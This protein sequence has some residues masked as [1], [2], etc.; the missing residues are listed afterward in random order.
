[1]KRSVQRALQAIANVKVTP[2]FIP[3]VG[4]LDLVTPPLSRKPGVL[5]SSQNFEAVKDGGYRRIAGYERFN[6]DDAPSDAAYSIMTAT[7]TGAVVVGDT[8]TGL[9]SGATGVVIALPGGSFVLTKIVGTFQN[10]ESLQ[11][12][13]VT[14][15]TSTSIATANTASTPLLHAT[16]MNA[17]ADAY[18]SDIAAV[19]GEGAIL[20]GFFYSGVNY[21]FRNAVGGA[22]AALYK[23]T[24]SG[25]SLVALGRE[26]AFTS[27]GVTEIVEGNTITGATSA[28]TAVITRVVLSS[29]SW[30]AGTAAGR[31]YFASQTGTFQ[32]ENIDVGASPNLATIA[33]NSSAITLSPGGRYECIKENFGG[34]ANTTRVYGCDGVN[35]AFEFDGTVFVRIATGMT[36]DTPT[37]IAAHKKHLFLSFAGSAQHSGTGTPYIW[38]PV[39]GASELAMGDTINGFSAQPG[40]TT[41]G[42]LAIFTRNRLSILYGSSSSD[43][44]LV[45]YRDEVGA[46]AHTIQDVG[47]TMFLDDRGITDIQTSQAFGNFAHN[48]LSDPVRTLVNSYRTIVS[49][50]CISRDLSQYRIF[51]T[52]NYGLY[53]TIKGTKVVGIM[54]VLFA[55]VVRCCWTAEDTDGSEVSFFGSDDG[56][57]FQMDKGTSHDGDAIEFFLEPAYNFSRSPRVEKHYR[58][59]MLE[60]SGSGY[61]TF[62]LGYSLGYGAT[63]IAQ[64]TPLTI[65]T[66][67]DAVYW[68]TFVWDAFYWDGQTLLP[69]VFDLDGDAENISLAIRGSSDSY[70]PFTI[71]GAFIHY[72]PRKR[73]RP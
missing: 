32:A 56:W 8:L 14:I 41:G 23:S 50:S 21:A 40:S 36:T 37:H 15:A 12:S 4:G 73:M 18:R 7:I 66:E 61:A 49:A 24:T 62:S 67:F 13:A 60:I 64:P 1:M 6:G 54:P 44:N 65:T 11:V 45:A 25:W 69:S 71:T 39:T 42:A 19:P 9:T 53:V 35:K 33:G 17:A 72:T 29:G 47:F 55:D 57:V 28:A 48:A 68:D 70:Q 5:R 58:D 63:T 16:Y 51:F 34:A 2:E 43:W 22:T 52:N 20:G 3:M 31:L 26:L 38:A 30:A 27:G 59:G 46:Y 10:A